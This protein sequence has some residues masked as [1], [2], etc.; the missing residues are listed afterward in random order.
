MRIVIVDNDRALVRS[1][2]ILLKSYGHE[3]RGFCEPLEALATLERGDPFD[4]LFVDYLMPGCPG[5]ELLERARGRFP[6]GARV[7]LVSG[8]VDLIQPC[9]LVALGVDGFFSKPLDLDRIVALLGAPA[10]GTAAA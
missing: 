4:V 1:L 7:Y 8:H 9:E 2:S 3:V 10:G 6:P 5:R